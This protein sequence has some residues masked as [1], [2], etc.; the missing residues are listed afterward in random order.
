[1]QKTIHIQNIA[2]PALGFGTYQLLGDACEKA[3][4]IAIESGYRHIDTAQIYENE[5]EIG[6]VL[7]QHKALRDDIFIT[8]KIWTTEFNKKAFLPAVESSLKRLDVDHVNLLLLHWPKDDYSNHVALEQAYRA[9]QLGY[10][11]SIGVSNFNH[12]QME[13]AISEAPII[14]NQVEYHPYLSQERMLKLCEEHGL[15]LTAYRPLARG[16]M[17]EEQI[18]KE[19]SE[20]YG[21][22]SSQIM[23]R[24][25]IQQENVS[26]I[27]K[28]SSEIHIQEN[29]NI[30][31][32]ELTMD[33]MAELHQLANDGR[34]TN[35]EFAP[36]WNN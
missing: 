2:I 34:I 16:K 4:S 13:K 7:S 27:P 3:L 12:L 26:A 23:L 22:S 9:L 18:W 19:L 35:P 10:T 5:T 1:M 17:V 8:T 20:K 28:A 15:M 25:L 30:F 11:K 33:E 24:W 32:F 6:R 29:F 36:D 14:C 21:K 31:D